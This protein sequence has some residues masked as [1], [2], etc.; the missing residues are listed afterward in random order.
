MESLFFDF[1]ISAVLTALR[2]SVK[3]PE[4]KAAIRRVMLKIYTQIGLVF[5]ADDDFIESAKKNHG[6]F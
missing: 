2:A 4:R 1:G 5:G 3:N 6:E